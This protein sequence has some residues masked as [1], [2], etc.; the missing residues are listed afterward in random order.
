MLT[1]KQI[2]S[3]IYFYIHPLFNVSTEALDIDLFEEKQIY[4]QGFYFV[5][6]LNEFLQGNW[7]NVEIDN[8]TDEQK[9]RKRKETGRICYYADYFFVEYDNNFYDYIG[10][11]ERNGSTITFTD[12]SETSISAL[13][14]C[15]NNT[16][17]FTTN[18]F[19]NAIWAIFDAMFTPF[20]NELIT[21]L[22][23]ASKDGNDVGFD[24]ILNIYRTRSIDLL[25]SNPGVKMKVEDIVKEAKEAYKKIEEE[26]QLDSK[27]VHK[28]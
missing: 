16:S 4:N 23:K 20:K 10:A 27:P 8:L 17:K 22:D 2:K 7:R 6:R 1:K 5:S 18:Y 13:S 3:I 28:K 25:E 24:T 15:D 21:K 26:S 19:N 12:G 14:Y 11:K 9:E